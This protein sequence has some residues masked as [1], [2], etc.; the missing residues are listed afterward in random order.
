MFDPP[1]GSVLSRQM[2]LVASV[3]H[4]QQ[5]VAELSQKA[6]IGNSDWEM[7]LEHSLVRSGLL[8]GTID[9]DCAYDYDGHEA[10]RMITLAIEALNE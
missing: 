7:Q 4:H 2:A 3:Q 9:D 1:D 10:R 8:K 6:L 5:N